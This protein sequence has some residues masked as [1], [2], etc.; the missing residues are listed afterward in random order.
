MTIFNAETGLWATCA[1]VVAILAMVL[2]GHLEAAIYKTVDADGNVVFTDVPP[3]DDSQAVKLSDTSRYAPTQT[4]DA[5]P[6]APAGAGLQEEEIDTET[7]PEPARYV[8][9]SIATPAY[10][11]AVRENSGNVTVVVQPEPLLAPGHTIQLLLDGVL[12]DATMDG[13]FALEN[14]DRGTHTLTARI[15]DHSDSVLAESA[16]STFHMLRHSALMRRSP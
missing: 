5:D 7:G 4:D 8:S 13:V 6:D 16:D 2:P 15:V 9:L 14:V 12:I 1:I 10:D 11:E 3:S